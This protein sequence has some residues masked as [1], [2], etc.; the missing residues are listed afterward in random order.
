MN[1]KKYSIHQARLEQALYFL[2]SHVVMFYWWINITV[3]RLYKDRDCSLSRERGISG[4]LGRYNRRRWRRFLKETK[5]RGA[6]NLF[7]VLWNSSAIGHKFNLPDNTFYRLILTLLTF[8]GRELGIDHHGVNCQDHQ[9]ANNEE[10]G[11]DN[12]VIKAF[13]IFLTIFQNDHECELTISVRAI[14]VEYEY[15]YDYL[16]LRIR[17]Y[18]SFYTHS[19][20]C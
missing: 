2:S 12:I 17:F 3:V 18:A 1:K 6:I 5:K 19:S 9:K 20:G 10:L 11:K 15:R 4:S 16:L 13:V 7:V 8:I 14:S